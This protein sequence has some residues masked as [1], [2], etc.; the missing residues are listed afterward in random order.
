MDHPYA[1]ADIDTLCV[2]PEYVTRDEHFFGHQ[3]H[4]LQYLLEVCG[5]GLGHEPHIL[6]HCACLLSHDPP[7]MRR[8]AIRSLLSVIGLPAG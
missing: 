1:G 5:A 3:E 6:D 7:L 2:G 4:S 8:G